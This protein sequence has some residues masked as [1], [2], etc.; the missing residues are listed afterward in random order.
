MLHRGV[1]KSAK[2]IQ[3]N[4]EQ[5]RRERNMETKPTH[6]QGQL[7][8]QVYDLR[9]EARLRQARDWFF[10]NY[11]V[12]TIEDSMR[13]APPGTENGAV[14]HQNAIVEQYQAVRSVPFYLFTCGA[15]FNLRSNPGYPCLCDGGLPASPFPAT[16]KLALEVVALRQQLAVL[17]RKQPRPKLG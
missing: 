17:K 12:E 2:S 10:R 7:H 1:C 4:Q 3:D 15:P 14:G 6:E 8:L 11:I 16:H 5:K 13:I 9:R